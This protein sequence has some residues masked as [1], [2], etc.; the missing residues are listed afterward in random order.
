[1]M[2]A[3]MFRYCMH[4]RFCGQVCAS[5]FALGIEVPQVFYRVADG[6]LREPSSGSFV[7]VRPNFGSGLSVRP[8]PCYVPSV[9]FARYHSE[10]SRSVVSA[11]PVPMVDLEPSKA[12][13]FATLDKDSVHASVHT[14]ASLSTRYNPIPQGVT[15]GRQC[16]NWVISD[17][18]S[19][20]PGFRGPYA[21]G[22]NLPPKLPV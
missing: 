18:R 7:E 20:G 15:S 6:N 13:L 8:G 11:I 1:M 16:S 2:R 10:V 9:P 3:L 22:T 5:R 17:H 12:P 4:L 14:L 21:I 19:V